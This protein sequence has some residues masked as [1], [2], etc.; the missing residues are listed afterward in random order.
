[1]KRILLVC[2]FSVV[3][4]SASSDTIDSLLSVYDCLLSESQTYLCLREARIDSLR[5]LPATPQTH[6]AIGD[7]YAPYQCDSALR[8]Y[9]FAAQQPAEPAATIGRLRLIYL[10]ASI[11][12][13]SEGFE[14][15][16]Q[17][18]RDTILHYDL[19]I[20]Y[21][22]TLN[23]LYGEAAV[24]SK[25]EQ[26]RQSYFHRSDLYLDSLLH[27]YEATCRPSSDYYKLRLIQARNAKQF[28]RAL[29]LSD[30]TLAHT[31]PDS[32][33][34][35]IFAYE[36]AITYREMGDTA[37]FQEWLLRSAIADVRSG[38]TDNGSSWML[39]E[40]MYEKGQLERAHRYIE[41]SLSNAG[42]FNARL[43]Y[44]Q[45]N[46][47]GVMI[48]S[49]YSHKQS[50]LSRRIAY[51]LAAV[52]ALLLVLV[53]VCIYTIRQNKRLHML[54]NKRA[55]MNRKLSALNAQL[56]TLNAS[57]E[58]SNLVKEQYICRYLE[59]Y[60]DY[61]SRITKMARKAGEKDPD[62]FMKREMAE[63]YRQ[64][65]H[66]FLTLYR[67]FVTDFNALLVPEERIYP[68]PGEGLTTELRIFALIRLG[69]DSSAKIAELLCYSPNTI[70]NYRARVRNAALGDRDTFEQR[71]AKL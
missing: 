22:A 71:V 49:T 55:E 13:Y 11:G 4:F 61:I 67:N 43:R 14:D 46:P 56:S 63:F 1:M 52:G 19:L 45:I 28:E 40:I 2:L 10:M 69:I 50:I 6:L 41:Y 66:T 35:A 34:Y 31:T 51:A 26:H 5:R 44:V 27:A 20:D 23:H 58:E 25:M 32:H 65:D 17:L 16:K 36:R 30:T 62:A 42:F 21:H 53:L 60:R 7:E 39:A 3:A 37:R 70:Y 64:F 9:H 12:Y 59:V 48:N 38:I 29:A 57:L 24:Y 68:K 33:P 47:L 8:H 18:N 54:S 15:T